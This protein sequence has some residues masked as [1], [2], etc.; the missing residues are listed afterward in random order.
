MFSMM[1]SLYVFLHTR[2]LIGTRAMF[3]IGIRAGDGKRK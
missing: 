3:G 2:H 1:Q